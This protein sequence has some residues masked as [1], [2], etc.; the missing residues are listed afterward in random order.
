MRVFV[1]GMPF[2]YNRSMNNVESAIKCITDT[3]IEIGNPE[4]IILFGS[5]ARGDANED[6]DIDIMVI[7]DSDLPRHKRI[8]NYTRPVYECLE[9]SGIDIYHRKDVDLLVYTPNE[10]DEWLDISSSIVGNVNHDGK[11]LYESPAERTTINTKRITPIEASVEEYKFSL[12]RMKTV[13]KLSQLNQDS[14]FNN[15]IYL[16]AHTGVEVALRAV[17]MKH[18]VRFTH[19][20]NLME[21]YPHAA[22]LEPSLQGLDG[23]HTN[24]RSEYNVEYEMGDDELAKAIKCADGIID[25]VSHI[26]DVK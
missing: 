12:N 25:A 13:R 15:I 17:M 11:I 23:I 14:D 1:L 10:F 2:K 6:S 24:M 4:K 7:E 3:I 19:T 18:K 21:L 26:V 22:N 16:H 20:N 5:Q 9:A 8:L